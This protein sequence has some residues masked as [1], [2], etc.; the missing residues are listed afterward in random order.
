MFS[1]TFHHP[2][3]LDLP[4][5]PIPPHDLWPK[6]EMA[7]P[8]VE[9]WFLPGLQQRQIQML[10]LSSPSSSL[11]LFKNHGT[12]TTHGYGLLRL[13]MD[14]HMLHN[15]LRVAISF[16]A[17]SSYCISSTDALVLHYPSVKIYQ[18]GYEVMSGLVMCIH[19]YLE[20]LSCLRVHY[21]KNI[22]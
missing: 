7:G 11:L 14:V 22:S 4:P 21:E 19:Q 3:P 16:F 10:Y 13:M 2:F 1:P 12:I 5:T 6:P 20:R 15:G 17:T 8:C 18:A 9:L